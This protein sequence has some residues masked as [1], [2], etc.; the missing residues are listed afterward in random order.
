MEKLAWCAGPRSFENFPIIRKTRPMTTTVVHYRCPSPFLLP[1]MNRAPFILRVPGCPLTRSLPHSSFPVPAS[2]S[3][4]NFGHTSQRV[5][6]NGICAHHCSVPRVVIA[7]NR[8]PVAHTGHEPRQFGNETRVAVTGGAV[9]QG[10]ESHR[11]LSAAVATR[12]RRVERCARHRRAIGPRRQ[13]SEFSRDLHPLK[14]NCA[15]CR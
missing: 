15:N 13:P 12:H 6:Q 8:R 11:Y 10:S 4:V 3:P 14:G 2:G 1:A 5:V 9:R 7:A